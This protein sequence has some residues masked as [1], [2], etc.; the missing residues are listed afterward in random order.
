MSSLKKVKNIRQYIFSGRTG[1]D[2]GGETVRETENLAAWGGE[3]GRGRRAAREIPGV[4][5]VGRQ[6]S[7]FSVERADPQISGSGV[8]Y[9][10]IRDTGGF[11]VGSNLRPVSVIDPRR[12]QRQ[13]SLQS[14]HLWLNS[15]CQI[16]A[17]SGHSCEGI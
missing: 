17:I 5:G 8:S 9:V 11:N 2:A 6:N 4:G 13:L 10:P 7:R 3:S 1:W 14:S 12:D 16:S 15:Y